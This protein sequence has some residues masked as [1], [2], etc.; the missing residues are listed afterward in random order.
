MLGFNIVM[1]HA[2]IFTDGLINK[3]A[4]TTQRVGEITEV[5]NKYLPIGIGNEL[6]DTELRSLASYFISQTGRV[7]AASLDCTERLDLYI[8]E[9]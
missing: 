1:D 3:I 5:D 7:S 6:Q 9:S 4:V 2:T 8:S